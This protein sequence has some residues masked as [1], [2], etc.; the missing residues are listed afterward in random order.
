[1]NANKHMKITELLTEIKELVKDEHNSD[2]L[3]NLC[4][5]VEKII[6]EEPRYVVETYD[7]DNDLFDTITETRDMNK[8]CEICRE[9]HKLVIEDK[10]LSERREP[11][12]WVQVMQYVGSEGTLIMI[13][14]TLQ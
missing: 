4:N 9:L 1:M 2:T 12:D 6:S 10:L 7:K 3:I 14:D 8:A 13:G 5:D 11:V